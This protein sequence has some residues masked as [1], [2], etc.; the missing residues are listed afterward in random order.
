MSGVGPV[1]CHPPRKRFSPEPSSPGLNV[2][3]ETEGFEPDLR[4]NV[5]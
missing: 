1:E 5:H 4:A 3:A 2:L